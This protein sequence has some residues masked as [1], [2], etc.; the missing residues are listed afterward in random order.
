MARSKGSKI[1]LLQKR[2]ADEYLKD[3]KITAAAIRAGYAEATAGKVGWTT[4][5]KPVVKTY[6]ATR[7]KEL[8]MS[9][10]ETT[11]LI[12]NIAKGN[13]ADYFTTR[14]VE[15]TPRVKMPLSQLIPKLKK[16][17]TFEEDF[18]TYA[19]LAGKERRAQTALIEHL[20][21][22]LL[23]YE[24]EYERNPS[25]YRITAGDTVLI[26]EHVLDI[27]KLLADK[28]RGIIKSVTPTEHGLKVEM[29]DASNALLA[30][31]KVHGLFAKDNGQ[32]NPATEPMSEEQFQQALK[33]ARESA[34]KS[35]TSK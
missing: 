5:R 6:I 27:G 11:K 30:L 24:M 26:D 35:T 31:A 9:A 32:R 23:R 12:T 4:L 22:N 21:N 8:E 1:T 2:F 16:D 28:E 13:L 3:F 14:K 34:K 18:I 7:L 25:A 17:I 20:K 33:S 10:E 29:Y 15:Y 19:N